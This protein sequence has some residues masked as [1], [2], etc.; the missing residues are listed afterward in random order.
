MIFPMRELDKAPQGDISAK[1][2]T[3]NLS[4]TTQLSREMATFSEQQNKFMSRHSLDWKFLF[5]DHRGPPIIGYL[6][7]EVLGTSVYDY[8]HQDDLEKVAHCHEALIQISE[9]ISCYYRFSTKGQEWIWLQ[10]RNYITYNQ[11]NC[12]PEFI[13]CMHQVV[14]YA[15]VRNDV[16]T[17]LNLT[18]DSR[19]AADK[20][21]SGATMDSHTSTSDTCMSASISPASSIDGEHFTN[22]HKK[23]KTS[24][25]G[26]HSSGSSVE[27]IRKSGQPAHQPSSHQPT[28]QS[29]QPNPP[30][31]HYLPPPLQSNI[32]SPK[33]T[34]TG[35]SSFGLNHYIL[36]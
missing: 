5:L 23:S 32:S 24:L 36:I 15:E 18:E 30:R 2:A 28:V 26:F 1:L 35:L 8:Y 20:S 12:K 22:K 29:H 25:D 3:A 31:P 27:V 14:N 7:F 13:V 34:C 6:P 16:N 33:S 10:T 11:W 9:G 21:D 19:V 17:S 4:Q